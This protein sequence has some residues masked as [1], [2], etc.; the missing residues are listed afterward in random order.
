MC[1]ILRA[2]ASYFVLS[3]VQI[4]DADGKIYRVQ[5]QSH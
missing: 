5:V 4:L 2:A 1:L 3:R